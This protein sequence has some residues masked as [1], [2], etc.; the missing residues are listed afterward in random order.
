MS[1]K[2]GRLS[3]ATNYRE[4]ALTPIGYNYWLQ[5]QLEQREADELASSVNDTPPKL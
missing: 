5:V 1:D 4:L 3:D 2:T